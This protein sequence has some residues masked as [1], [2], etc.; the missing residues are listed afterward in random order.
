MAVPRVL[1]LVQGNPGSSGIGNIFLRQVVRHYP[2]RRLLRFSLVP[3]NAHQ[4]DGIWCGIPAITRRTLTSIFP[5]ASSLL[6]WRFRL[7][8]VE[9]LA[10]EIR[11]LVTSNQ[12]DLIWS[13]LNSSFIIALTD[14]LMQTLEIPFVSTVWDAPEYFAMNRHLDPVTTR[15]LLESYPR[16]LR[17]S[18]RL[19]VSCESMRN[20]FLEK[21]GVDSLPWIHGVHHSLWQDRLP[22]I[23]PPDRLVIGFAGS[24]YAKKEWN[25]LLAALRSANGVIGGHRVT[26]KF[27]GR[28]PRTFAQMEPFVERTGRHSQAET[29][30]MLSDVDFGYLPYWFDPKRSYIV[31]TSF[32]N[33][34]STY[35]AAGIPV[36]YHGPTDSSPAL[37]FKD[38]PVGLCCHSLETAD[39]LTT[40]SRLVTDTA[41]RNSIAEARQAALENALGLE[42]MLRQFATLLGIDRSELLP[43]GADGSRKPSSQMCRCNG[44]E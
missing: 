37:F 31:K 44:D 39:I 30:E 25:T 27:I 7:L 28:F 18:H 33:K 42:V 5:I 15:I 14:Q 6:Y 9:R 38:Y 11:H 23:L 24:L 4:G 26:I 43:M 12:V 10:E 3:H 34:L 17:R 40:L 36:F 35:L 1:L 32:P 8:Y 21:Y 19:S 16:V 41:L 2:D 22:R 13:V 20:V 29:L